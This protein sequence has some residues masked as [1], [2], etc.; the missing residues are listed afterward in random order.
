MITARK[1]PPD[2]LIGGFGEVLVEY[3]PAATVRG[4]FIRVSS[5]GQSVALT[6]QPLEAILA[7]AKLLGVEPSKEMVEA[8]GDK[9]ELQLELRAKLQPN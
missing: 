8:I 3:H 2:I 6:G 1:R 9:V 7:M 5:H 4:G